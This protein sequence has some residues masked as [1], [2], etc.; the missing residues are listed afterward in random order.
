MT[1]NQIK[2]ENG[3]SYFIQEH[4][5]MI[6]IWHWLTFIL[7]TSTMITVLLNS[8]LMDPRKDVEMVQE[9]LKSKGLT[10]T[11]EQAFAVSHEYE[12][13]I[14][15]VHKWIGYGIAF[16][17]FS[18]IVIE[19]VQ[20]NEEKLKN[21]FRKALGLYKAGDGD[22]TEYRHYLGTKVSYF[23]FYF[24]LLWMAL[25]GL[26][27]AFGRELGIP[28]GLHGTIK[29]LHS[30]GQYFMY[31]FVLI[32]LTGIVLAENGKIRGIVSGMIHGNKKN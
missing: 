28:R 3:S 8:T 2:S 27:L 32:H 21:R 22:K 7:I 24:L 20:P 6:R 26:G 31:A 13:M 15:G 30:L 25:S 5:L 29:E 17:L 19:L 16:L 18:R 9:Q 10:A 4:S 23:L 11:G 1:Q 14:W 12:D